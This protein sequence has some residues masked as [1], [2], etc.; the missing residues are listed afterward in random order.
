MRTI[1][2]PRLADARE[3]AGVIPMP[4]LLSALGFAANERTR[5]ASCIIQSHAH[6]GS[7]PTSFSWRDDGRWFC[8]SRNEGGDRITLVLAVKQC[9]FRE[10]LVYL[11]GI[12]GVP[13]EQNQQSEVETKDAQRE[14][15]S[16]RRDAETLLEIER[17]SWLEAQDVVLQLEAIRRNAGRRLDG[18]IERWPGETELAWQALA[19]VYRQMP[20]AAAAYNVISFASRK[21]R[22]AFAVDPQARERLIN[23]ALEDGHVPDERGYRFG[24]IL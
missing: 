21:D 1:A 6:T 18:G 15:Q 17:A 5:R 3:I 14:R 11:A 2:N 7:N 19:E 10:A 22:L 23:D 4:S 9:S 20:R 16:L 8:F 12:A 24:L 13:L